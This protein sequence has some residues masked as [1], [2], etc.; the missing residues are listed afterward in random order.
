WCSPT[1]LLAR[2]RT[3]REH[4]IAHGLAPE[5]VA[6]A[7]GMDA[8]AYLRLEE[9]DVWRG[10]DRQSTALIDLLGLTPSEYV[11]VTGQ[12]DRLTDLLRRAVTT[13][14]QGHA[15]GI[16]KLVPLDRTLVED[17]LRHLHAEYRT[18]L[19]TPAGLDLRDRVLEYFWTAAGKAGGE[20]ARGM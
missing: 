18:R 3:L 17:V 7:V 1:D 12:D 4:R 14:W 8:R 20:V 5:D 19:A 13:R 16:A 6:R 10:T 2:P 15:R 9:R 11:T